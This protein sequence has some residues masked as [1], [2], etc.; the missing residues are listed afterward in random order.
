[1]SAPNSASDVSSSTS[2]ST[3]LEP[4]S[5][6]L[7]VHKGGCHCGAVQFEVDAPEDLVVW[8]CNCSICAM[9][10]NT[11]FIVPAAR[12]RLLPSPSSSS[13]S[14]SHEPPLTE[15]RFGTGVARHRF[16]SICGVQCFYHPRSNPDG[17]AVTIHCI[18]SGTVKSL[19]TRYFD[20][21]QWERAYSATGIAVC[22][23]EKE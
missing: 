20:G 19:T 15:Y 23:K 17:V 1:M 22:S 5:P 14:P 6:A 3:Q 10:R 21:L 2:T 11:H 12:F 16:C 13:S 18:T 8:D 4:G 9:K 7:V